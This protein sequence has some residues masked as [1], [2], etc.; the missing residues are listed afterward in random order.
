[1]ASIAEK[2][3]QSLLDG[4]DAL[5]LE[6][7]R[8]YSRCAVLEAQLV[9]AKSQTTHHSMLLILPT[10]FA[11]NFHPLLAGTPADSNK[12]YSRLA[13]LSPEKAEPLD[14]SASAAFPLAVDFESLINSSKIVDASRRDKITAASR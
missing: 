4:F 13:A 8:V 6:Y 9:T 5:R 2:Q 7:Q 1:M 12:Q 11:I 10:N 3:L 14:L